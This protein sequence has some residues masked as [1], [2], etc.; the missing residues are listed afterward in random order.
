MVVVG[1]DH[2]CT[3]TEIRADRDA[4]F[5]KLEALGLYV[6]AARG[7]SGVPH[8]VEQIEPGPKRCALGDNGRYIVGHRT[9]A[10]K[11]ECRCSGGPDRNE[12][13]ADEQMAAV[14]QRHAWPIR[15]VSRL[16]LIHI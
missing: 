9:S 14:N 7:Q 16:S 4:P 15:S 6:M 8:Q 12:T 3:A 11:A 2:R 5:R 13:A 1:I 10:R